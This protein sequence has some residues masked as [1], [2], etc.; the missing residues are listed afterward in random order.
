MS[1]PE[2]DMTKLLQTGRA[3]GRKR[4]RIASGNAG[5]S[6]PQPPSVSVPTVMEVDEPPPAPVR[7]ATPRSPSLEIIDG[8]YVPFTAMEVDPPPAA[9]VRAGVARSPSLQIIDGP[10]PAPHP[11]THT[12]VVDPIGSPPAPYHSS[13]LITGDPP[14][15]PMQFSSA[16]EQPASE[17]E[18]SDTP[19]PD[20]PQS[21]V[22][23]PPQKRK[24]SEPTSLAGPLLKTGRARSPP[25]TSVV[26]AGIPLPTHGSTAK[27]KGKAITED[28]RSHD[29]RPVPPTDANLLPSRPS[30]SGSSRS[31]PSAFVTGRN[32]PGPGMNPA[33]WHPYSGGAP[34]LVRSADR[35][36]SLMQRTRQNEKLFMAKVSLISPSRNVCLLSLSRCIRPRSLLEILRRTTWSMPTT[37]FRPTSDAT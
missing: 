27:G 36:E 16:S 8:P 12:I 34:G 22:R 13:R 20:S 2:P 19:R 15:S 14:T 33:A 25:L 21:S 3:L 30:G 6:A 1:P 18:E 35:F 28:V 9:T 4:R 32:N 31:H 37:T 23:H 24:R 11:T 29:R 7:M 10:T 26:P 17:S 5:A